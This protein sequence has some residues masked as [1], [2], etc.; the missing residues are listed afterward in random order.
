M[1]RSRD[2]SRSTS[3]DTTASVV[4]DDRED[5]NDEEG[6]GEYNG[7]KDREIEED[8]EKEEE[9]GPITVNDFRAQKANTPLPITAKTRNMLSSPRP[10][11]GS[12]RGREENKPTRPRSVRDGDAK[13]TV[14]DFLTYKAIETEKVVWSAKSDTQKRDK[15]RDTDTD[16]EREK[17]KGKDKDKDKDKDGVKKRGRGREKAKSDNPT[18]AANQTLDGNSTFNTDGK[19]RD[20]GPHS[21][22]NTTFD[23]GEEER[24][25]I[26]LL[27]FDKNINLF[28]SCQDLDLSSFTRHDE[29]K[30]KDRDKDKDNV[31]EQDRDRDRDREKDR[32]RFS[33]KDR[34]REKERDRDMAKS[35]IL[36]DLADSELAELLVRPVRSS[37]TRGAR[38]REREKDREKDKERERK[39]E[40]GPRANDSRLRTDESGM[41][42]DMDMDMGRREREARGNKK[43]GSNSSS[44]NNSRNADDSRY[45]TNASSTNANTAANK[46]HGNYD[47]AGVSL[48]TS[49]RYFLLE[50]I[51]P[52]LNFLDTKSHS[53]L[54]MVAGRSSLEG[55]RETTAVLVPSPGVLKRV[56]EKKNGK[57]STSGRESGR[58]GSG[59]RGER[60]RE[61]EKEVT[62]MEPKRLNEIKLHME[63][64]SA[65][66][67]PTL[68]PHTPV[69]GKRN[70]Q[71]SEE[72]EEDSD[73][74]HWKAMDCTVEK[75][76]DRMRTDRQHGRNLNSTFSAYGLRSGD[77]H[78]LDF[79][80]TNPLL[81]GINGSKV[82][83]GMLRVNTNYTDSNNNNNNNNGNSNN[84]KNDNINY[85]NKQKDKEREAGK[86]F[87]R[88]R[89]EL[90]RESPN[91]RVAVKD[92]EVRASYSFWMDVTVKEANK[93]YVHSERM[94]KDLVC[95][96]LLDL[97]ELCLD[98]TS[99]QFYLGINVIKNVL[100]APPPTT[101]ASIYR[102]N[103]VNSDD[104]ENNNDK[105]NDKN[106]DNNNRNNNNNDNN[107]KEDDS[108][109]EING[110]DRKNGNSE[111]TENKVTELFRDSID[112]NKIQN[113]NELNLKNRQSRE[114]I[115]SL[116]EDNFNRAVEF[117]YG[118]ARV[119][120][121]YIGKGTWI[122]RSPPVC[123][124]AVQG[125]SLSQSLSQSLSPSYLSSAVKRGNGGFSLIGGGGG[126]GGGDKETIRARERE[127]EKERR[128]AIKERERERERDKIEPLEL[129]ETGFTG[130]HATFNY[131]ED[132][133]FSY[134][135]YHL[136]NSTSIMFVLLFSFTF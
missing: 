107:N 50:L 72:G 3:S 64:V 83:N 47:S 55:Q 100:L 135:C 65:F 98:I 92:F 116:I 61:I 35:A 66:T 130:V 95:S 52:Q 88:V 115:K 1:K 2:R 121:L 51:D 31:R 120:D 25:S 75:V 91:L 42:M 57:T 124:S 8:K 37:Y 68:S 77:E 90:L 29:K 126:G 14:T 104:N 114:E 63:K 58:R 73:V 39:R 84:K 18:T 53:S 60:E 5:E 28:E 10:Y 125:P 110:K 20:L 87:E 97:P 105:N 40:F 41:D 62:A 6:G 32:D 9:Y 127:K 109:I 134:L 128:E 112:E 78:D 94:K 7:E 102:Q 93:M 108:N 49:R 123:V 12:E 113:Q 19:Y 36:S 48:S 131:N 26:N 81:S 74:V 30:T 27:S 96:F 89:M 132:R 122:L 99:T 85:L 86:R 21:I 117:K 118:M 82:P 38:E 11:M 34:D 69:P 79:D 71:D 16:R 13:A 22:P 101:A 133:C 119:V 33:K 46:H 70:G 23:V 44:N 67:V 15:D 76:E 80:F 59:E 43:G 103:K 136:Y 17:L 106:S 4:R 45:S 24:K 111:S 54:I 129:L 56:G